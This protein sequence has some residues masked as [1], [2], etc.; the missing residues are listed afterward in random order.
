MSMKTIL[1]LAMLSLIFVT[2]QAHAE[3]GGAPIGL[4]W[5]MLKGIIADG[6]MLVRCRVAGHWDNPLEYPG[7]GA[8]AG[9]LGAWW[10]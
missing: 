5:K 1:S 9:L 8:L 4:T 2:A 7:L 10:L 6:R 3:S